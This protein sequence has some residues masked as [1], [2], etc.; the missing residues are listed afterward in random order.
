MQLSV[1]LT[2]DG[3]VTEN[4]IL[5]VRAIAARYGLEIPS[6]KVVRRSSAGPKVQR[7]TAPL[8]CK[9]KARRKSPI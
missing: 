1:A 2:G 4:L 7:S 6:V 8:G 3:Q 9:S 5:E